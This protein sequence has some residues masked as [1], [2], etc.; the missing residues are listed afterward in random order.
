MSEDLIDFS[1]RD[2][3]F[4]DPELKQK[5]LSFAIITAVLGCALSCWLFLGQRLG[6]ASDILD[7]RAA[8]GRVVSREVE[9]DSSYA[10]RTSGFRAPRIKA[11]DKLEKR[12]IKKLEVQEIASLD[13]L[14]SRPSSKKQRATEKR[15]ADTTLGV[16]PAYTRSSK[17]PSQS[18]S[19]TRPTQRRDQGLDRL[20]FPLNPQRPDRSSLSSVA[21]SLQRNTVLVANLKG[22]YEVG[23]GLDSSGR[24]LISSTYASPEYLSRVWVGGTSWRA[25]L[26]GQDGEL[27]LALIQVEG[28]SFPTVP[29]APAPPARGERLLAFVSGKSNAE[30]VTCRA[31]VTFGKAGFFLSGGLPLKSSGAPL[32]NDRGELVGCHV[33]SLPNT[34]GSGIHL[35]SDTAA[36]HRL[37]RGYQGSGSV[38]SV[39]SE[40]VSELGSILQ[41][42]EHQGETRRGRVLP[43]VGLSDFHLGISPSTA[44]RWL[45][46]PNK[47]TPVAG[48]EIWSSPAPPV[49]LYFVQGRLALVATSATGFATPDGLAPGVSVDSSKI[50]SQ[51]PDLDFAGSSAITP[52]LDI[53]VSRGKILEFVVKPELTK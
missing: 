26:L 6:P 33:Q 3:E 24:A 31:G 5:C 50:V 48:V 44:E 43:G 49:T 46:T 35:A 20:L 40:A 32:L 52:G 10:F 47:Q 18:R 12:N 53:T 36:I 51:Y 29:L 23:L 27:G 1:E 30:Q 11:P 39:L 21:A 28:V 7:R 8:E 14:D 2:G 38:G 41:S 16:V 19:S 15:I 34:P 17:R 42:I 13:D 9:E 37:M 4:L 22:E 45:S 25:T